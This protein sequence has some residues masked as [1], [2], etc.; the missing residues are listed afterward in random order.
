[1][2]CN[3]IAAKLGRNPTAFL[4]LS[5]KFK[6][7]AALKKAVLHYA[8]LAANWQPWL[9]LNSRHQLDLLHLL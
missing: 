7:E 9:L 5:P 6:C 4:A 1:M 8:N 2:P 3:L